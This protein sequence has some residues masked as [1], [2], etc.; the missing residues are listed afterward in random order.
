VKGE[1]SQSLESLPAPDRVFI[2]GG[3]RCIRSVLDA[4]RDKRRSAKPVICAAAITLETLHEVRHSL[5]E[6]GYAA[7]VVQVAVTDVVERGDVH[8][9]NAQNPVFL[10]TGRQ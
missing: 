4:L 9:M 3:G 2:G 10:I 1:I 6:Y 8:M 7:Q 5:D